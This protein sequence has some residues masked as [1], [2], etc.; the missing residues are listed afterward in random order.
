MALV[1]RSF[2]ALIRN[3]ITTSTGLNTSAIYGFTNTL[4]SILEKEKPTHLAVAFDT[5]A[6]TPRHQIFPEYKAQRDA[7]PEELAASIAPIKR[8]IKAFNIPILELDGY[9]ADDLIGTLTRI[10]DQSGD[11]HSFMVT[12]DKDFAQLVSPHTSM[13]K[14]GRQGS[15]YQILDLETIK[16]QWQIE[17]PLQV[18]DILGLWGDTSDNI[19]GVP[20][21]G[22]KTAKKLIAQFGSIENL[23]A[24]T[25]QLKGKQKENVE[26]HTEQ[27]KLS[28]QLVTITRDAPISDNLDALVVKPPNQE[29]LTE[30]FAEFEFKTLGKRLFGQ[31]SEPT[32]TTDTTPAVE[33]TQFDPK[34]SKY[35]LVQDPH[36]AKTLIDQFAQLEHFCFDLETTSLDPRQAD[37]LG[38]ALASQA[39][40]AYYLD[41]TGAIDPKWLAPALTS[42]AEKIGHNLK[43][44]LAIL[45]QHQIPCH[46]PYFDTMLVH[47]LV[48]PNQRHSM[49]YLAENL[50]N[51][52]TLKLQDLLAAANTQA[53]TEA[54]ND[55]FA[56]AAAKAKNKAK[57]KSKA[58]TEDIDMRSIP[59]SQLA[60]Y[61]AEDADITLQLATVLRKQ[62]E[63]SGMLSLYS[64]IEAPLLPVL[65]S[66]ELNGIA[67]DTKTLDEVA[68]TLNRSIEQLRQSIT[69]QAGEPINLNS[70]KQLGHLLFDKLKLVDKPKKTKTGQYVTNEQVLSTL[71]P[72][73]KI[74]AEILEYREASKLKSTYVDALPQHISPHTQRIHTHLHQLVTATGR[75]ASSDPN[76]QNIP[77]RTPAGREIR[78][79][80]IPNPNGDFTLLAADYS[81]IELR[82]MAALAKDQAMIEAFQQNLDIHQSTAAK[83][84]QVSLDQ[85]TS[86]MRRTAKMVNFGIIYGISAFGLSQRLGIPRTEAAEII[87]TY[88]KEYP[89]IAQFMETTVTQ[90][91][92]NGY[93]ETLC[94]RRR[95]MPELTSANHS[96]RNNAER[97]AINTPIQ[98]TA[99][100]MI[101]LAMIDVQNVLTSQNTQSKLL[102]Q[103]HDELLFDLHR[104][105]QSTLI[106]IIVEKMENTLTLPNH[107]PVKVDTGTGHHWLA[108]H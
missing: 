86:D 97:A 4:V 32:P 49:D 74:V 38:I 92:E 18:I 103:V 1:Y 77:V 105:E 98:G 106:P 63:E 94:G 12:P 58:T 84:F 48:S 42:K 81:Q 88:L 71:A 60:N 91:R 23:L 3:P 26:N 43:F 65:V 2:F 96:I 21:I 53:E 101:K 99:A 54:A 73:H 56:H 15:D 75:L 34:K 44:D 64:R 76:L 93:A 50:L 90:A 24:N 9:E 46:G 72:N 13:W 28:K 51:Y 31:S 70:P 62:L 66:V 22:E 17:D 89:G 61:A 10:A 33:L 29:A 57:N 67:V 45:N 55:L 6:P 102:L 69:K 36:E 30:L 79:A 68:K 16:T 14:P 95:F 8:I 80:F 107:V 37:I 11:F 39:G 83:V 25:D 7:M 19:P 100:D 47:A 78:K 85:V 27:A 82:V 104:D 35:Q 20:G 40:T 5:S 59:T 108:A 87:E 41:C 52:Q